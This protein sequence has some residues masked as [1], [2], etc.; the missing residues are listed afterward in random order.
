MQIYV[1]PSSE[2]TKVLIAFIADN[3]DEINKRVKIQRIMVT[4]KNMKAVQAAGIS[5]TP[6]LVFN[7]K[8][9]EGA[10]KIMRMLKPPS[11]YQDNFGN[12]S[13][14]EEMVHKYLN[15]AIQPGG[16]DD[17][18]DNDRGGN[19]A[20]ELRQRMAALEKRRNGMIGGKDNP[21]TRASGKR[22]KKPDMR[23]FNTDEDFVGAVDTGEETPTESAME[24][25]GDLIWENELNKMADEAGRKV[26][27]KI[28]K[29]R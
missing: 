6:T 5:K 25:N 3:I 12:N 15:N 1:N 8:S 16:D 21:A 9:Y 20:E 24:E 7:G 11:S 4:P 10:Q 27:N 29:R 17:E 22:G 23:T 19:R 2:T 13:T 28:G 18:E 26:G 14:P